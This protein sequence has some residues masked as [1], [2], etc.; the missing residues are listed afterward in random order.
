MDNLYLD[1]T[2]ELMKEEPQH[3]LSRSRAHFNCTYFEKWEEFM[4]TWKGVKFDESL[5][6]ADEEALC[7]FWEK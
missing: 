5:N 1:F 4:K 6:T 2:I 3:S 7:A